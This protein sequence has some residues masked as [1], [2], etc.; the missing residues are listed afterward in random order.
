M[1]LVPL[2]LSPVPVY[3]AGIQGP[4]SLSNPSDKLPIVVSE[5][6]APLSGSAI[7]PGG[8][9]EWPAETPLYAM[10]PVGSFL[11]VGLGS[12]LSATPFISV[13]VDPTPTPTPTPGT[14]ADTL[15]VLDQPSINALTAADKASPF[16]IYNTT[17][18]AINYVVNGAVVVP[19]ATGVP[20]VVKVEGTY[21][22]DGT[23][24]RAITISGMTNPD[25]V[26]MGSVDR[27]SFGMAHK[28]ASGPGAAGLPM[29]GLQFAGSLFPA[30]PVLSATGFI[31]N[32]DINENTYNYAYTAYKYNP[33]PV[34]PITANTI[35]SG[36]GQLTSRV[37]P[38]GTWTPITITIPTGLTEVEFSL[39]GGIGR[40]VQAHVTSDPQ[41]AIVRAVGDNGSTFYPTVW[42][43][44]PVAD[45]EQGNIAQILT[46]GNGNQ[47]I[48]NFKYTPATGVLGFEFWTSGQ[49]TT[50]G[51][52]YWNWMGR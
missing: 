48:R 1:S 42:T 17:T 20:A 50:D 25:L 36:G 26:L 47:K 38:A 29:S 39:S 9:L 18:N 19:Q 23:N 43:P 52:V 34:T 5:S 37:I 31:V 33:S 40:G 11:S 14:D 16:V 12:N 44:R 27:N 45:S 4:L 6:S 13:T 49:I 30:K 21:V 46:P 35:Q 28:V 3:P 41:R 10:G 7:P 24:N 51:D 2:S 32:A 22:G 15:R 8:S